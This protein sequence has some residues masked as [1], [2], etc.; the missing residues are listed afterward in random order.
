M[1][2]GG[3]TVDN[4]L[5]YDKETQLTVH[6]TCLFFDGDGFTVYDSSG[7]LVY[8]VESYAISAREHAEIVLMD[9]LGRCLLTVRRKVHSLPFLCEAPLKMLFKSPES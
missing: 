1:K 8:R 9:P 4:S 6:K 7:D 2:K 3:V 5:I